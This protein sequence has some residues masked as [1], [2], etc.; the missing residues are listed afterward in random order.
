M[1]RSVVRRPNLLEQAGERS[2]IGADPSLVLDSRDSREDLGGVGDG[3]DVGFDNV[4]LISWE[5]FVYVQ[6]S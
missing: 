4:L 6:S 1:Q 3:V 2:D 5:Q